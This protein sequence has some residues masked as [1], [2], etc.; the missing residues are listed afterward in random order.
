MKLGKFLDTADML[1]KVV[2]RFQR[3][4]D[5]PLVLV[6]PDGLTSVEEPSKCKCFGS[7]IASEIGDTLKLE[8]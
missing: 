2:S 8:A 5:V 1:L 6:K 3:L 7:D 4:G